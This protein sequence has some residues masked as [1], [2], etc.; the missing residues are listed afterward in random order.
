VTARLLLDALTAQVELRAGQSDDMEGIHHR[1]GLGQLICRGALVAAE[2]VHGHYLDPVAKH[3][4][5]A[6][7][8][9]LEGCC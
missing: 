6:G 7:Q 8:P 9:G 5:L 3:L 2:T 4:A 1:G